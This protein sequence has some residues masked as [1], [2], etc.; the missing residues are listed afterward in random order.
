MTTA[1]TTMPTIDITYDAIPRSR[2]V[3]VADGSLD[4]LRRANTAVHHSQ[5]TQAGRL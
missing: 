4:S 1:A 2:A 3:L 5:N